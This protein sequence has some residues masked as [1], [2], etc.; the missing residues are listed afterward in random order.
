MVDASPQPKVSSPTP[1]LQPS[2]DL[3]IDFHLTPP[4]HPET[5]SYPP[6]SS[7]APTL[8]ID[9]LRTKPM[10]MIP[11]LG[12]YTEHHYPSTSSSSGPLRPSI[13]IDTQQPDI[14]V[15]D[16]HPPHQPSPPRCRP[17]CARRARTYGIGGHKIGHK[18]NSMV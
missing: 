2:F 6:T 14:D 12:L 10:T 7:S 8:P 15:P 5:P 1:P 4:M 9:P 3:G 17:Q 11:T 13:R 18:N 16:E